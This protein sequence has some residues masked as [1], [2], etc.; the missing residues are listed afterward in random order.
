MRTIITF[1]IYSALLAGQDFER[2]TVRPTPDPEAFDESYVSGRLYWAQA[3]L[4]PTTDPEF[5]ALRSPEDDVARYTMTTPPA[6]PAELSCLFID[7]TGQWS[8]DPCPFSTFAAKVGQ[9]TLLDYTDDH[10]ACSRE[11]TESSSGSGVLPWWINMECAE[12]EG[13]TVKFLVPAGLADAPDLS[14]WVYSSSSF[15]S[16]SYS[17]KRRCSTP[18]D[19]DSFFDDWDESYTPSHSFGASGRLSKINFTQTSWFPVTDSLC[20]FHIE[21]TSAA[22]V[23]AFLIGQVQ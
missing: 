22:S 10:D 18:D 21:Q 1:L 11:R 2:L 15:G 5:V 4:W 20:M 14:F 12:G 3:E 19:G 8:F 23:T 17:V 9:V 16:V 7:Q 6:R 13:F